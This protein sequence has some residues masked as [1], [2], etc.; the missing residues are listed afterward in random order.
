MKACFGVRAS[1]PK[2]RIP[3]TID[4]ITAP[5]KMPTWRIGTFRSS[6]NALSRASHTSTKA[7]SS[8]H[9]KSTRPGDTA[10]AM[11]SGTTST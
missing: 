8:A 5:T 4:V 11:P 6:S 1:S 3:A 10:L 2:S 9:L 7:T